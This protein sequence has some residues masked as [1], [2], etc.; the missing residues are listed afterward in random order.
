MAYILI[1][2]GH[3]IANEIL[4]IDLACLPFI[5]YCDGCPF[6]VRET[7]FGY[8]DIVINIIIYFFL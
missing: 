5:V 4:C 8:M 1:T 2:H 7:I 3:L 6:R